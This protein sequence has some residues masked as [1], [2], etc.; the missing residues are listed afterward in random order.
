MSGYNSFQGY[1]VF[2]SGASVDAAITESCQD[3]S[4]SSV[5]GVSPAN[6]VAVS[7]AESY[8]DFSEGLTAVIMKDLS[9]SITEAYDDFSERCN[10]KMPIIINKKNI[11][12]IKRKTNIVRVR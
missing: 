6:S 8:D 12:R 4:E 9:S 3:F 7:V 11:V 1:N 10:V 5:L 2:T